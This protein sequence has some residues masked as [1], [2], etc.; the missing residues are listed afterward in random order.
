MKKTLITATLI[1]A[2]ATAPAVLAEDSYTIELA[3]GF[4]SGNGNYNG[5][6]MSLTDR[7][8]DATASATESP[9]LGDLSSVLLNSVTINNRT[10]AGG[11]QTFGSVY[12]AVYL[13][14]A[15]KTT[16]TFVGISNNV[17]TN[18]NLNGSNTFTFSDVT[19]D[20]NEQYQYLFVTSNDTTTL[21]TF[22]GYKSVAHQ[23][24]LNVANI[25]ATLPSGDG[26]YKGSGLNDW[27]GSYMPNVSVGVSVT[28]EPTTAT[29]SLLALAGLCA[30][31]RRK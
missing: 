15:D 10:D 22:D 21:S 18:G 3:D 11:S 27:E 24:G 8:F 20:P 19:L 26:T 13:Y 9:D 4:A 1:A 2:L 12:L 6:T 29:L 17:A 25:N 14:S 31:R 28:P 23:F 30:R 7:F 5:W 16:G